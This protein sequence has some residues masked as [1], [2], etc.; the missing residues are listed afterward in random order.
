[1]DTYNYFFKIPKATQEEKS[2]TTNN[3]MLGI[4]SIDSHIKL[5]NNDL[6]ACSGTLIYLDK[7]NTILKDNELSEY[8]PPN[9]KFMIVKNQSNVYFSISNNFKENF[10]Q[11][12]IIFDGNTIN[13]KN[14]TFNCLYVDNYKHIN[15]PLNSEQLTKYYT[16]DQVWTRDVRVA[17]TN[18][19]KTYR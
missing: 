7:S 18:Y 13:V 4:I 10:N 15:T 8:N 2:L 5:Q 16:T 9:N 17:R 19:A 11:Q 6:N 14:L 1:M 3:N 12:F